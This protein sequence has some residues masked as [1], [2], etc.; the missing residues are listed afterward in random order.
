[1]TWLSIFLG[2]G[3]G[4]L[5]RYSI[6]RF[7]PYDG[8]MPWAT[9][10]ANLTACMILGYMMGDV[11]SSQWSD[12]YRLMIMTGFCGGLSTFST[13]SAESFTLIEEGNAFIAMTYIVISL[14]LCL[15]GILLGYQIS[16][17]V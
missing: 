16:K 9:F 10:V 8:G 14:V 6:S 7:I 13:F 3:L 15:V 4:S 2:G 17:Y 1:M 11:K 5:T 12:S